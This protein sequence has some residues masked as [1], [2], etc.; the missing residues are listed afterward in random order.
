MVEVGRFALPSRTP[1]TLLHTA[2]NYNCLL[3]VLSKLF[4]P[5]KSTPSLLKVYQQADT[6]CAF[7]GGGENR[8]PV[9]NTFYSTSYSN[10]YILLFIYKKINLF[11]VSSLSDVGF[12]SRIL[13]YSINNKS[14]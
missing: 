3:I 12:C 4:T 10:R 9:Q 6:Q 7:G 2:I 5:I 1:F 14:L 8:T 13:Q 11:N